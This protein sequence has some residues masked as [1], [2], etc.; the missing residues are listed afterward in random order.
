MGRDWWLLFK[1]PYQAAD[2]NFAVVDTAAD[3]GIVGHGL[4]FDHM[5]GLGTPYFPIRS[6]ILL[7]FDKGEIRT[8]K[9]ITE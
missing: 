3:L 5:V 7:G 4:G 6:M 2:C 1:S 8:K 9:V